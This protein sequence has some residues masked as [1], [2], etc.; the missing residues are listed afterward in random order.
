VVAAAVVV[1]VAPPGVAVFLKPELTPLFGV[2]LPTLED[3]K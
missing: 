1:V 2:P 3:F